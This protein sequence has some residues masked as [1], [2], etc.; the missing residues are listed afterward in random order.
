MT[1]T[2]AVP[3]DLTHQARFRGANWQALVCRDREVLISGP[4]GTGKSLAALTKGL[5]M[6]LA[7]PEGSRFRGLIIRKTM[8]SL[9]ATGLDTWRKH[10]ATEAL[11]TGACSFYG[12]SSAEPP[13][14]RFLNGSVIVIGG[15]DRPSKIMSS[16]YDW[17]FVQEATELSEEDWESLTSRLRNGAISFQQL[18]GDCNPSHPTHWL[19]AR[20][21]KGQ[22]TLLESRHE[23]NPRYFDDAGIMTADGRA[24]IEGVLDQL[25]G[26]RKAR[27]RYGQWVAAEGVIYEGF[28]TAVH[29]VDRFLPPLDWPRFWV[30]DFG[31]SHPFVLQRW[32][33][34]PDGRL[35]MYREQY[36][37]RRLVEDHA[38]DVM[39]DVTR[40]AKG[41]RARPDDTDTALGILAAVAEGRRQ[42]VEPEPEAVICDHDAE[43]RATL[44]KHLGR[45]TTPAY[46]AVLEGIEA[47]QSRMKI[48]A[49]KRPR[50]TIMRDAVVE[51]DQAQVEAKLPACTAEE[52][53]GHVWANT[54]KEQ[55]VKEHDDGCDTM[56]YMVA[57]R[58]LNRRE[59]R[60]RWID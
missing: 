57:H 23:D 14:Y 56:R 25:T 46:K 58:D 5:I 41:E 24:Y 9:G 17:I 36:R 6:A 29:L 31:F 35:V 37:T 55:P 38:R 49:D 12:G 18:M 51:R 7:H 44:E 45:A 43:G 21:N 60:F 30:V 19:K 15:L 20:C 11:A 10:V 3:V 26:P 28:D 33:E 22:T 2:A 27:L 32:A 48:P 16:E 4:A 52:I 1:D 50:L 34:D 42:W 47:V 59:P 39:Y 8:A 13:Q 54:T 53:P 40:P